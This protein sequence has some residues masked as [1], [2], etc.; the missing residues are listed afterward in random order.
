[1]T[2]TNG[3]HNFSSVHFSF[4]DTLLLSHGLKF[5]PTPTPTSASFTFSKQ[6]LRQQFFHFRDTI[7]RQ[8]NQ[9]DGCYD[10]DNLFI[11]KL[12]VPATRTGPPDLHMFNTNTMVKQYFKSTNQL[13]EQKINDSTI[14]S[15]ARNVRSNIS[16]ENATFINNLMNDRTITIKPSDKNLGICVVDSEWYIQEVRTML[17]DKQ[18]YKFIDSIQYAAL[19]K[20]AVVDRSQIEKYAKPIYNEIQAL[21]NRYQQAISLFPSSKQILKF[22]KKK[23][24]I[25]KCTFPK[26]YL[27][28]KVH[29]PPPLTGRPIIPSRNWITSS[30]SIAVDYILQPYLNKIP[31][32]V[33][34]TKSLVNKLESTI[35]P[36]SQKNGLLVT[37]DIASLYTNIDTTLGLQCVQTFLQDQ[38]MDSFC[39]DFIIKALAIIMENNY[40]IFN[41]TIHKQSNGTAMGTNSAP[42]YANIFV[43][44]LESPVIKKYTAV[45]YHYFRYLDDGKMFIRI[46]MYESIKLAFNSIHP[47]LKFEFSCHESS[48]PF[49]DL[50][51]YKGVRFRTEGIFDLKTHQKTVNLYLYI[52]YN[53][54]HTIAMKRSFI[55]TELQRY[56]RNSSDIT[57]YVDIKWKFYSRLRDRGY[58]RLFLD[59][60]FSSIQY[61]DRCKY[62]LSRKSLFNTL[63]IESSHHILLNRSESSMLQQQQIRGVGIGMSGMVGNIIKNNL[64]SNEDLQLNK[65]VFITRYDRLNNCL[66]IGQILKHYFYLI[67][68]ATDTS[69]QIKKPIIAYRSMKSL[70]KLLVYEKARLND[71]YRIK[72]AS[73]SQQQINEFF[74]PRKK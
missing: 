44:V 42:S 68:N 30:L 15:N 35:I 62:L 60:V 56:V 57:V 34:D 24:P 41:G 27:L 47:K 48:M 12:H 29:K 40:L 63:P 22:V 32:L 52:P 53:S 37:F 54:Y 50:V 20:N 25:S 9:L 8:F 13:L 43:Y 31:W 70:T 19:G 14:L 3:I 61:S 67:E 65:L 7:E 74:K 59:E 2:K 55:S 51:I 33:K 66:N 73:C 71:N 38:Y 64:L 49:L 45:L 21:M 5:I 10:N 17:F 11:K 18:T 23:I 36:N 58:P 46:D 6:L 39:I 72:P 4:R 28:I 16:K 69:H 1:M 26:M